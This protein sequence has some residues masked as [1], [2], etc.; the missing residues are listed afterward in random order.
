MF[1]SFLLFLTALVFRCKG[2][3]SGVDVVPCFVTYSLVFVT[4]GERTHEN[5]CKFNDMGGIVPFVTLPGKES[6]TYMYGVVVEELVA[7]GQ[8]AV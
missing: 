1:N 5:F 6:H 8:Y 2:N 4:S 7:L 3:K